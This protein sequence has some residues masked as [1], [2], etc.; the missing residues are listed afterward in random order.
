MFDVESVIYTR[1]CRTFN[2]KRKF[3]NSMC[4]YRNRIL[5]YYITPIYLLRTQS[6]ALFNERV[7]FKV[8]EINTLKEPI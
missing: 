7:T 2:N 8:F 5:A 4:Q 6:T 1:V 3:I